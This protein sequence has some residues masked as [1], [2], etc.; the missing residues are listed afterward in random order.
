MKRTVNS[1]STLNA[2]NNQE[3]AAIKA[4]STAALIGGAVA[5]AVAHPLTWAALIYGT[6]KIGKNAYRQA[7]PRGTVVQDQGDEHLFI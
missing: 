4:G 3:K 1:T 5:L 2:M 6:Y 7:A